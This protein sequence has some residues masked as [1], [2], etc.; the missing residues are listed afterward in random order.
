MRRG[1]SGWECSYR[2]GGTRG[3]WG[4]GERMGEDWV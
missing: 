1:S 3:A 4:G 2:G